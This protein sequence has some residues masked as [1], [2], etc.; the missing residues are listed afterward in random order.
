MS[1]PRE[2]IYAA[3]FTALQALAPGQLKTVSRRLRH[4]D[5]VQPSEFPAAFQVQQDESATRNNRMPAKWTY[6]AEWWLYAYEPDVNAAPSMVLNPLLD[7]ITNALEMDAGVELNTLG[8]RVYNATVDGTVEIIE[9]VLGDRCLAI[10]PIR[11][12]KA[13]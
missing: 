11:I 3:L 2:E 5:E 9:G 12:V 8:G 13:D 7:I 4:I 1:A 10:V 6:R